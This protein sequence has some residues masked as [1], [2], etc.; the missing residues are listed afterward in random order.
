MND[1]ARSMLANNAVHGGLPAPRLRSDEHDKLVRNTQKWVAQTFYGEMLK[2]MR[3][4]PFRSEEFEGG[5]GGEAFE[6]MFD[7]RVADHMSQAAGSKLVNS[8]VDRIESKKH[9][10]SPKHV[11]DANRAYAQAMRH[12]KPKRD[13][14]DSGP[15][16]L[17]KLGIPPLREGVA[18]P[19]R[20]HINHPATPHGH[21]RLQRILPELKHVAPAS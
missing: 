18:P 8:I 12:E 15:P 4:S 10:R 3:K 16:P 20:T 7:Q 21:R 11:L 14:H 9:L 13:H 5:R 1:I 17:R 19:H 6:E 2:E